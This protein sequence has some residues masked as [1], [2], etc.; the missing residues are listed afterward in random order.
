MLTLKKIHRK[1]RK[2]SLWLGIETSTSRMLSG[3]SHLYT[4]GSLDSIGVIFYSIDY[5]SPT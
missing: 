3:R 5:N 1:E 4:T 2:N